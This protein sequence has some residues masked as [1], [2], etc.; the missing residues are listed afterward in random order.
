MLTVPPIYLNTLD[1]GK[2][3]L[4][5]KIV[6]AGDNAL[7]GTALNLARDK[8]Y[9]NSYGPTETSIC[10]THYR[11]DPNVSY[12]SRIPIGKPISNTTIYLLDDQ[13]NL[14]PAGCIGEICV[15]GIALARGYL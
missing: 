8:A 4:V 1:P 5:K 14:V 6:S 10:V 3:S 12:D 9:Y 2:L 13:M 15:S 11:V 7:L